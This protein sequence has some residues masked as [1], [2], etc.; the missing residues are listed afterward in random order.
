MS[1]RSDVQWIILDFSG[2]NDIDDVAIDALDEIMA[3]YKSQGIHFLIANM[4]GPVRD[5]VAK[6]GWGEKY[7]QRVTYPS[8]QRALEDVGLTQKGS[9]SHP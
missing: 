9:F 8:I 5:L 4:K 3:H 1:G 2:V 7:G 6:A